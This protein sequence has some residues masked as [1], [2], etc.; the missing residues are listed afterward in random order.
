MSR[1]FQSD[2]F[3]A[4]RLLQNDTEAFEELYRRY[5]HSLFSYC[6]KKLHSS[7][8][9]RHIVRKLFIAL[10]E[11]RS[12]LPASFSISQHL[13]TEV[14]TEVIICLNKKLTENIHQQI[15]EQQI[16]TEFSVEA[17]QKAKQPS[18]TKYAKPTAAEL[19]RQ[20]TL[21]TNNQKNQGVYMHMKWLIQ[22]LS[23]KIY[24]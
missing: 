8:D 12:T 13:Y 9:A 7:D 16:S 17:L 14:R 15:L 1:N 10:W 5:W 21:G 6:K 4:D 11:N 18:I 23:S 19:I 24:S 20:Q 3:L 22:A 2:Q